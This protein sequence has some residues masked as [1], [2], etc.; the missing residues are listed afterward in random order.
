M[1]R[2][3]LLVE[4]GRKGGDP[5]ARLEIVGGYG[6]AGG[7]DGACDVGAKDCG[8]GGDEE[9]VV[10][11]VAVDGVESDGFDFDEELVGAWGWGGAVGD[12]ES[13]AL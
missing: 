11:L 9:A 4:R 12:F 10:A 2:T 5:G 3:A 13:G 1:V 8:V 6:G 7:E